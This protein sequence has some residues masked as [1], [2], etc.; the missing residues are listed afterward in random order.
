VATGRTFTVSSGAFE[1]AGTCAGTGSVNVSSTVFTN[2]GSIDPG[3]P[4]GSLRIVGNLPQAS[5][6]SVNIELGG[7]QA[8][9]Q[10]DRLDITG[11]AQLNGTLNIRLANGFVPT[12]GTAF[13]ALTWASRTGDFTQITGLDLG[14]NVFLA[15]VYT[16]TELLLATGPLSVLSIFPNRGGDAGTVSILIRGIGFAATAAVA[17]TRSGEPDIVGTG[18]VV[19]VGGGSLTTV[20]GLQGKAHGQWNLRITNPGG[21]FVE[22]PGSFAVE[23]GIAAAPWVEI[24]GPSNVRPGRPA[25]FTVTYGNNGNV[26]ALGVPIWVDGIPPDAT[27]TLTPSPTSPPTAPG[28]TPLTSPVP[29]GVRERVARSCRCGVLSSRHRLVV[30]RRLQSHRGA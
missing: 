16:E 13:R 28:A 29:I 25:T 24:V 3:G 26:D 1:N 18:T 4:L 2:P 23:A 9:V 17:L 12:P 6:S 22:I 20:L 21:Q 27:W 19:A 10:Y 8:D 14:G 7:T 30:R 15:P 5:T 11:Q